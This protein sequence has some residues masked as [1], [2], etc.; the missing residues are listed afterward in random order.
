MQPIEDFEEEIEGDE[1]DD[2]TGQE[3]EFA[4]EP[5]SESVPADGSESVDIVEVDSDGELVMPI[6]PC[7]CSGV[8]RKVW[9]LTLDKSSLSSNWSSA[10]GLRGTRGV[11][12]QPTFTH[13]DLLL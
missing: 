5:V 4:V 9:C 1:D 3:P 12:T 13:Q 2:E 7:F 10:G 8:Y 6:C 11:N